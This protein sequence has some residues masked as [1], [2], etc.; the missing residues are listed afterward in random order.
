[1]K[2]ILL[3]FAVLFLVVSY[4]FSQNQENRYK[5]ITNPKLININKE[6]ARSSFFS[7]NS[8]KDARQAGYDKKG[9]EFMLLNGVWKFHFT[10]KF[11]ER[12]KKDFYNLNY[13]DSRWSNIKVPGNIEVQGFGAPIYVNATYEFCSP[14]H[15]PFWNR[16]NPPLVP[17]EFNP[18]GT[19]RKVFELPASWKE[20]DI[21]L[22]S[23]ATK[24]AAY[25]YLNGEFIGMNK[26]G[27]L[28]A[29]FN[30][31][32]QAKAGK[33]VLAVQVHRFSDANYMECQDFWRLTGFERDVYLYTRPK[34]RIADFFAKPSLD[35]NYKHGKFELDVKLDNVKDNEYYYVEYSLIN[36]RNRKIASENIK[37]EGNKGNIIFKKDIPNVKKWSAEEPNLYT[38]TIELKDSQRKTLEAT[39]IKVGFRTTEVKNKQFLVNGKAV[40]VKGVNLHEHDELTGHYVDEKT[41]RKDFELFRKY[42]VNTVR[43]SHY[44]QPELFYKL[45]DEYGVYVIDEANVETH[46][47]GYNLNK[48]GTLGND[49]RFLETHLDRTAGMVERDKN[50]PSVI[51]WSLGNEAGNGFNFYETYLATKN[52]DPTRPVQYERAVHEWNTDLYVPMYS[53]PHEIENYAKNPNAQKPLILCEYAHAMGNSLGNFTEYWDVIRKYPILQGGCIWDWVDQGI[54]T[55]NDKGETYWAYGGDFGTKGTPSAGDFCI[56][57]IIFPDRTVKPHT[58]EM[59]K[60]YQNVWFKNLNLKKGTIDIYNENFFID[61]SQYDISYC[62]KYNGKTIKCDMLN[63]NVKPQETKTVSIGSL[64]KLVD[65]RKTYT[66]DFMVAQKYAK[67][68]IPKNWIVAKDQFIINDKPVQL[69]HNKRA[70]KIRD[71]GNYVDVSGIRFT[72]RFDKE[73]GVMTSYKYRGTEYINNNYGL[74]PFFWRA[75]IDNDYGAGLPHKLKAWR[76]ASME[77]PKVKSFEFEDGKETSVICNYEYPEANAKWTTKYIIYRDGSIKVENSFDASKSK[78]QLIPRIGMRMQMPGSF[79]KIEYYGRGPWENYSDRKTASFV[80]RH[81]ANIKNMVTKYVVAQESGHHVD[82]NWMAINQ[83]RGRGMLFVSDNKFEFN[84]S[85]YLLETVD[86]GITL[87]RD[88]PV[89]TKPINKHINAYKASNAV[90]VF[91]DYRMQGVGGNN[92]WGELPM[93]NY[94][95]KPNS[96]PVTY[97]FTLVPL[98]NYYSI[99]NY[100][101]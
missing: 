18:T 56:N 7:F 61:L 8:I 76:N 55:K 63:V 4:G 46:G 78:T 100:I 38:L 15:S 40:L 59:R 92:S 26:D 45:A 77:N 84:V 31:T 48:G 21:F 65:K 75:P 14:G 53:K 42:N 90:D 9:S 30:I 99:N 11:S 60:V 27:K 83:G 72:A 85:N 50:H 1:M 62:L 49:P 47:M 13:D 36:S 57:G 71:N 74:R 93:D 22:S 43:T 6:K 79:D 33:N 19:Y 66:V 51:T 96:T 10:E 58:E 32:K 87:N 88:A 68:L 39:A 101:K 5:E 98:T 25:Y 73:T 34:V 69:T 23:D 12:P 52:L 97:S 20:K 91:I 2:K 24:G 28:P 67:R 89:G 70:A 37:I 80:D 16:P 82:V 44:P 41:M 81:S 29:R 64:S 54:K 3:S 86:N 35:E 94:L 95:I 17:E